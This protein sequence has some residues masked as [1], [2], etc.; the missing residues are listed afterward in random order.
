MTL[1]YWLTLKTDKVAPSCLQKIL[2]GCT[3][4]D[5][6]HLDRR[7]SN[8]DC[9]RYFLAMVNCQLYFLRRKP[10][11]LLQNYSCIYLKACARYFKCVSFVLFLGSASDTKTSSPSASS[12]GGNALQKKSILVGKR[13]GL[14]VSS[15]LSQFKNYSQSKK[16]P[17]LSQRPSV[18]CSPD[19]E[20]EEGEADYSKF[21]EMKG[22][23]R[24][25]F[26]SVSLDNSMA[27]TIQCIFCL[28]QWHRCLVTGILS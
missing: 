18:F 11:C 12:P 17:V 15:M 23:S 28:L 9:E 14:G 4:L 3:V 21:L 5:K 16:N 13:P 26:F 22:N 10:Y 6:G 2:D 27:W 20:D 8:R 7:H 25:V 24:P 19:G 1:L